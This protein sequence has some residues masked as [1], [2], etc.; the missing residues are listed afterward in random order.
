[1]SCCTAC[2]KPPTATNHQQPPTTH[3]HKAHTN[4]GTK[5]IPQTTYL[6]HSTT[7][8][9]TNRR[10]Y[11]FLAGMIDR[12]NDTSRDDDDDD[13]AATEEGEAADQE[14]DEIALVKS[15]RTITDNDGQVG[16]TH[17]NEVAPGRQNRRVRMRAR[18]AMTESIRR[19]RLMALTGDDHAPTR[20]ENNRENN[21]HENNNRENNNR[22]N[23]N[24]D[25]NM[26]TIQET[27]DDYFN[28]NESLEPIQSNEPYGWEDPEIRTDCYLIGCMSCLLLLV[29]VLVLVYLTAF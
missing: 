11:Y 13:A 3:R 29:A 12:C 6:P 4:H 8:I 24:H 5:H 27:D 20:G 25:T 10:Y 22:D 26:K 2:H 15:E 19:M 17:V 21:N 9:G 28:D 7:Y 14:V 18:R 1:M 23:D 16:V